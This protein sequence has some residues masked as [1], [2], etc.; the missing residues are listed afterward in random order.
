MKKTRVV[1]QLLYLIGST[2]SRGV[3]FL[4]DG[5]TCKRW[6]ID[7]GLYVLASFF[8]NSRSGWGYVFGSEASLEETD[9]A[10]GVRVINGKLDIIGY[11]IFSDHHGRGLIAAIKFIFWLQWSQWCTPDSRHI[12]S[13]RGRSILL[14]IFSPSHNYLRE[15][16]TV[17][18]GD[19]KLSWREID[20]FWSLQRNNCWK[21]RFRK[22]DRVCQNQMR[23]ADR[24]YLLQLE[25]CLGISTA[26][27]ARGFTSR[28]YNYIFIQESVRMETWKQRQA[29]AL[30]RFLRKDHL[31]YYK[32]YNLHLLLR[33]SSHFGCLS[34]VDKSKS[35]NL[36]C[37]RHLVFLSKR[38]ITD[39]EQQQ[40]RKR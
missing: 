38:T 21:D 20:I 13:A 26:R 11:L 7:Q 31:P 37:P 24:R 4:F 18:I 30:R 32:Q 36:R 23:R 27:P 10:V 9:A 35:S 39:I 2:Y 3:I 16:G 17:N 15:H 19:P 5:Q 29:R 40:S 25:S 6:H 22:T 8:W 28:V 33:R 34:I 12:V 14:S 1:S